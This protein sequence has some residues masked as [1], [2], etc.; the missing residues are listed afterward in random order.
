[1]ASLLD[2]DGP[3]TVNASVIADMTMLPLDLDIRMSLIGWRDVY[4]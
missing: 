1:M 2:R 4:P 3:T